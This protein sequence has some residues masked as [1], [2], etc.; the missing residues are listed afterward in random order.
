MRAMKNVLIVG[1]G[2]REHALAWKLRQSPRVNAIYVAPGNAGTE[3][4]AQ[5]APIKVT[6]V[7]GLFRFASDHPVDLVV[8][9][10]ELP[11]SL[12]LVD[13]L[14]AAGIKA[15][16]PTQAA[17]R[18]ETSKVFAKEFMDRHGIPTAPY[19][20]AS[21]YKEGLTCVRE[22][23]LPVAIKADG[24]SSGKGVTVCRTME[25]AESALYRALTVGVFGEA[26]RRVVVET[27]LSGEEVSLLA[28]C[29]QYTAAPM[30]AAQD[31]KTI[32]DHDRG[33]N[34]GGMGCYAP[35]P[36]L[37]ATGLATATETILQPTVDGMRSEG[38]P[39]RG[40]LYAGLMLTE[41]GPQVLEFNVRFGDPETQ[42]IL[43]L[44]ENDLLDMFEACLD[45][46]LSTLSLRWSS[47]SCVC[48]VC[49][50]PGY[51]NDCVTG[52][53]ILGVIEAEA[54]GAHVFHAGT[55]QDKGRLITSGGRVLGVTYRAPELMSAIAGAYWAVRAICFE[56]MQYRRDIGAKALRQKS[57]LSAEGIR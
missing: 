36:F 42:A 35:T 38:M 57:R 39:F 21:S 50:A 31:H 9:G 2:G 14:N 6:D 12:G 55:R 56:G 30:L 43:P 7:E 46:R 25:Q 47:E 16:G 45:D 33:P 37:D 18:L 29:D 19:K 15:F 44:L 26:G 49:A 3:V 53:P 22:L 17:A 34:T 4:I 48:V 28:F 23:G 8:V 20:V 41:A 13:R 52:S 1:S 40:I 32:F 24:L 51:P 11:L 10:P 5:N 54:R 27:A